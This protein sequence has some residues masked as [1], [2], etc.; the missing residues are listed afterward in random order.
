VGRRR[1]WV[2]RKGEGKGR[3]MGRKGRGQKGQQQQN[4]HYTGNETETQEGQRNHPR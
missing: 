2:R 4:T 3:V 1:G